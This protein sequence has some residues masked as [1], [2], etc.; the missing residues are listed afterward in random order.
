[1]EYS[2]E[3]KC[4]SVIWYGMSGSPTAVQREYPKKFGLHAQLP[5]RK[6]IRNWWDKF[7]ETTSLT[8]KPKTRT[9]WVRTEL[10]IEEVLAKFREDPHIS[11]RSLAR[12]DGIEISPTFL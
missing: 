9:K 5:D 4:W 7:F 3:Q 6:S 8:K 12:N 11:P 2:G 10:K 1:M